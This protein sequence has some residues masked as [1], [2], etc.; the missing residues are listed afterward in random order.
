M[1]KFNSG[2][3][4]ADAIVASF[5]Y[6]QKAYAITLSNKLNKRE[7]MRK[8]QADLD[9]EQPLSDSEF[10]AWVEKWFNN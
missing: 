8:Q 6:H 4:L 2:D 3:T 5:Y 1:R 7:E 10:N 9:E